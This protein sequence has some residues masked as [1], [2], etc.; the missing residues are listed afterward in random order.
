M[1]SHKMPFDGPRVTDNIKKCDEQ[2]DLQG[3]V[4]DKISDGSKLFVSSLMTK[5]PKKR[6][7]H[8]WIVAYS[9]LPASPLG[10]PK[11]LRLNLNSDKRAIPSLQFN[12][13]MSPAKS[14]EFSRNLAQS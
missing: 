1:L 5:D 13:Q 7:K 8:P 3:N 11:S 10:K 9:A 6:I 4:W 12:D 2:P 14:N